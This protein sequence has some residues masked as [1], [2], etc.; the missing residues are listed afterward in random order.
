[1]ASIGRY[2]SQHPKNIPDRRYYAV[3]CLDILKQFGFFGPFVW[4][5]FGSI[6]R[7]GPVL[8]TLRYHPKLIAVLK[9]KGKRKVPRQS[10]NLENLALGAGVPKIDGRDTPLSNAVIEVLEEQASL[11]FPSYRKGV[12]KEPEWF[13]WKNP[14]RPA[15]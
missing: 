10:E 12:S 4:K 6:K 3:A 11:A 9:Y 7:N 2:G 14:H 5:A 1:M 13:V 15:P 8:R